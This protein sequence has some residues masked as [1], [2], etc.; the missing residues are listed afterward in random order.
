M[1]LNHNYLAGIVLYLSH[2]VQIK[3]HEKGVPIVAQWLTN[4][5]RNHEVEGLI[6]GLAQ[7]V[8]HLALP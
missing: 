2:E 4:L 8:K 5:S 3:T 1:T 7:W 6:P